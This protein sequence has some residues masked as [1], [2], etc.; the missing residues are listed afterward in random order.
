MRPGLLLTPPSDYDW[1]ARTL[2]VAA[3]LG[4][5]SRACFPFLTKH[6]GPRHLVFHPLL[7]VASV[8]NE[9]GSSASSDKVDATAGTLSA[10]QMLSTLPTAATTASLSSPSIPRRAG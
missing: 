9:Q 5:V 8:V 4:K 3:V 7:P 10:R 2:L 1:L 6:N